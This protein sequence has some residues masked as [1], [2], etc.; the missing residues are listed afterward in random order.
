[1]DNLE[2]ENTEIKELKKLKQ[3]KRNSNKKYYEKIKY[4]QETKQE[5]KK[6]SENIIIGNDIECLKENIK[7]ENDLGDWIWNTA[8]SG[9]QMIGS[10]IIQTTMALAVPIILTWIIP[11]K[12]ITQTPANSS[13]VKQLTQEQQSTTTPQMPLSLSSLM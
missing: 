3:N 12:T 9:I 11:R 7:T 6:E 5:T 1:M 10:T 13:S 4:K 2:S 8:I